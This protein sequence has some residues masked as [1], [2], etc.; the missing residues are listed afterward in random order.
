MGPDLL[1]VTQKR[2]RAWLA[3]WLAE[4]EKMLAEKDPIIMKLYAEYKNVPMPNM[5]LSEVE[6]DALIDY[7]NAESRR[8]SKT[9]R[10]AGRPN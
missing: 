7:M 9:Q 3:R 4:P 6:V 8:V 5:R 1:G 10:N 2:D